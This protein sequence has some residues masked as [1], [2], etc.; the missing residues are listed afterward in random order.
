LLNVP[1][2]NPSQ[3]HRQRPVRHLSRIK[4]YRI[5]LSRKRAESFS[6]GLSLGL[7]G[8]YFPRV[9]PGGSRDLEGS[10]Q[11]VSMPSRTPTNHP[12]EAQKPRWSN[13]FV[14]CRPIYARSH[15]KSICNVLDVPG[16]SQFVNRL[17]IG[18]LGPVFS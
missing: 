5:R 3:C 14:G 12:I 2:R 8:C 4:V 10:V 1:P 18:T 15:G 13:R 16:L 6:L 11:R 17:S 9:V 7:F